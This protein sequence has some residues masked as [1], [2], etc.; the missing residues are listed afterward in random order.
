MRGLL[1]TSLFLSLLLAGCE[2][3]SH[4]VDAGPPEVDAGQDCS[5]CP[6][7]CEDAIRIRVTFS[8][9]GNSSEVMVSGATLECQPAGA[10]VFCGAGHLAVSSGT[11]PNS[12]SIGISR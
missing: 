6:T 1:L 8:D 9:G 4:G 3:E 2:C 12:T 7:V 5:M 11:S 10:E